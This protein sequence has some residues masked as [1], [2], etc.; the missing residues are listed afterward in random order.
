VNAEVIAFSSRYLFP[1]QLKAPANRDELALQNNYNIWLARIRAE[2]ASD[3]VWYY[4]VTDGTQD[5]FLPEWSPD[6]TTIAFERTVGTENERQVFT[7]DVTDF[8]SPGTPQQITTREDIPHSNANPSWAVVGGATWISFVNTPV[9]RGDYDIGI[10][11][12]PDLDSLAWI[13]L[14]PSDFAVDENGVLSFTFDDQHPAGNASNLIAFA[15]PN[16]L[17][18]G[19][20]RVVARSEEQPDTTVAAPIFIN[21]KDSGKLTPHTFKYRP[22]SIEVVTSGN[23]EGYCAAAIDTIVPLP[24][25]VTTS[26]LDFVYTRGTIAVRSVPGSK[27][28]YLDGVQQMDPTQVP[29][30]TPADTSK[31]VSLTCVSS[32]ATHNVYVTDTYGAVCGTP[33][34]VPVA[35]GE[36]TFVTFRCPPGLLG[37]TVVA[38]GR[39]GRERASTHPVGSSSPGG[40]LMQ[41][42]SRSIWLIDMG[43]DADIADDELFLVQ[44]FTDGANFPVLS[45]DSKYVVYLRGDYT[46]WEL[47]VAEVSGLVAG[48][49][50]AVLTSVGLPGSTADFECWRKPEKISWLPLSEGRKIVVSLSPCKGGQ[51]D[52]CGIW[53]ADLAKFTD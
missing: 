25:T 23:L 19:N 5:D 18:V 41:E 35:N 15:S 6:G 12:W 3:T 50:Q 53:V 45:P 16:R 44:P 21:G 31:S 20:I 52:D 7:V 17:P 13:S 33:L 37:E 40:L 48:S 30:R 49:G 34:D 24:D 47:V 29:I 8:A 22:A 46:Y 14:D 43:D 11:R 9:G 42:D 2:E 26:V 27:L 39:G 36:T 1:S 28:V 4:R 51:S 38:G 10:M 32:D